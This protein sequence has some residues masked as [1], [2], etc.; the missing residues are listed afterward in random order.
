M[1]KLR[2]VLET[3]KEIECPVDQFE[4]KVLE[5]FRDYTGETSGVAMER[6]N[7]RDSQEL[8]AYALHSG[9]QSIPQITIMVREGSEHYVA[10]VEDAFL[11]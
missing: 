7:S 9:S 5:A 6:D 11:S 2:N 3:I 8:K 1:A 10:C 4:S